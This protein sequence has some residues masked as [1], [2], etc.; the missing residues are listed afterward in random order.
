M[1]FRLVRNLSLS[2]NSM[3]K[4]IL[5]ILFVT[6]LIDM[7]GTGMVFPIIPIIFTDPSSPSFMLHGTSQQQQFFI[8]GLVTAL[9]GIMQFVAAPILGELSDVFGRKKLLS[10]GIGILAFSQLLF[11]IGIAEKSLIIL[12]VSRSIAGLAAANFAIAQAAIADI[13]QPKDRAKN[14]G[15]IG[16]AFGIGFILGPLLGGWIAHYAANAA[17]P[18]WFAG[19]LGFLNLLSCTLFLPE[20]LKNPKTTHSFHILKGIHNLREA[21]IDKHVRR[22]YLSSFLYMAGFTFL[23]S[24]S[25]IFLVTQLKFSAAD[26]GTFFAVIGA[27]VVITQLF[28]LRLLTNKFNEKTILRISLLTLA[29]AISIYPFIHNATLIYLIIPFIAIPQGLSAA[30]MVAL[31]SKNAAPERQGAALGIN[32]SLIALSQGIVPLVAGVQ[33]GLIDIKSPFI[34]GGILIIIAWAVLFAKTK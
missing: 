32:G 11:A 31:V 29:L 18:F 6:L 30:N 23:V 5:P 4:K 16:G 19:I 12:L 21:Y 7:I 22:I 8:A 27:F 34:T 20:T 13:T 15:L 10:V 28:I 25:G 9:F 17:A 33:S 3:N 24:F 26:V 2:S 1:S 14:F